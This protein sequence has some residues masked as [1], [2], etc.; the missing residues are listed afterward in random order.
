[1]KMFGED[2]PLMRGLAFVFNLIALN[3]LFMLCCLPVITIGASCAALHVMARRINEG[4]DLHMVKNFFRAFKRNFRQ[5]T[6]AWLPLLA[7]GALL[8]VNV[9]LIAEE[10]VQSALVLVAL[11]VI[12]LLYLLVALYIFPLIGRYEN[13]LLGSFR[14]ALFLSVRHLPRTILL[15]ATVLLPGWFVFY[16]PAEVF[17]FCLP[18]LLLVGF[19]GIVCVQEKILIGAFR[20]HDGTPKAN[21]RE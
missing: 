16:G 3:M 8:Y 18:F 7:V 9:A 2:A 21:S 4:D 5:A 10:G 17:V 11:L 20:F 13:T 19:S 6:L 1:M 12:S 15:A 14:N